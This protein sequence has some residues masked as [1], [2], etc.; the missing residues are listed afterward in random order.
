MVLLLKA[1]LKGRERQKQ[2]W[3][4]LTNVKQGRPSP[5]GGSGG[6]G[7][8]ISVYISGKSQRHGDAGIDCGLWWDCPEPNISEPIVY[9]E[10]WGKPKRLVEFP[11]DKNKKGIRHFVQSGRTCLYLP[12][13]K[14]LEIA[15]P[16]NR[17]LDAL[18]EQLR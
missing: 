11:W 2:G 5:G 16:L 3:P 8:W 13:P 10:F 12:I 6:Y 9:A 1:T 17:L 4:H 14:S 7:C 15:D 18:L